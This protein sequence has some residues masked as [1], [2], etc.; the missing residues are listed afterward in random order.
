MTAPRL[1]P[2]IDVMGGRAVRAVAG[3]RAN[4]RPIR[5][6]I[7][8]S[9]RA[10]DVAN[11]LLRMARASELYVAD[12]D[13]ITG[14]GRV[15]AAARA[16][17]DAVAVPVW[18]DAGTGRGPPEFPERPHARHVVGFETCGDPAVLGA[19]LADPLGRAVALSIDLKA[20]RLIGDWRAWGLAGD[21][22]VLALARRAVGLGARALI[23]LDLAR[24]GTGRGTGTGVL[25]RAIR[26]E[27][28][29][30]DLLAGGG[31]RGWD[32]VDRLGA[33]GATGVLVA[34]ALHDGALTVPRPTS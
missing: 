31:V 26:N 27:F 24:V 22:D 25:L 7:S 33:A 16:V 3:D 15:S 10:A 13:A 2:V 29:D 9:T 11:A 21:R 34:T 4:Y 1:I 8:G 30:V 14:Q 6:P 12:L 28:P 20:G 23:V 18:L 5:C 19:A 17:L 32:D